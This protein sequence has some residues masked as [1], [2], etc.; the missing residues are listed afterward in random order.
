[1]RELIRFVLITPTAMNYSCESENYTR[2][3]NHDQITVSKGELQDVYSIL[4][5]KEY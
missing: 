5:K 1:M 4:Y 2:S 3:K